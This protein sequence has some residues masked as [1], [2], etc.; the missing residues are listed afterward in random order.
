M[1]LLGRIKVNINNIR[2]N[3]EHAASKDILR[4][5][6]EDYISVYL[7]QMYLFLLWRFLGKKKF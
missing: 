4:G 7:S 3:L 2:D 6:I 5:S 1:H